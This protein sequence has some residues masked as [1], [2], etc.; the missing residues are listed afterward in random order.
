MDIYYDTKIDSKLPWNRPD[1]MSDSFINGVS[2]FDFVDGQLQHKL[3]KE[4]YLNLGGTGVGF[5]L[6]ENFQ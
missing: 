2:S 6:S 1:I 3:W 5:G 4:K